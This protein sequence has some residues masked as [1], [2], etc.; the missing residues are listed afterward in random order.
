MRIEDWFLTPAERGNAATEIDRRR[1]DGTAWTRGQPTSRCSSTARVLPPALRG[2]LLSCSAATGCT[3]PTGR[4]IPTSA[5]TARAPRWHGCSRTCAARR[6]ARPRA[7][8]AVAP[9]PGALQRAGEPAPR[10]DGQ[11]RGRRGA[12]RRAGPTRREPP[13][14]AVRRPPRR[15][16][17]TTTSRS[18]AAS[19]SATAATTTT[20]TSATRRPSSS[21]RATDPGPPWHDVQLEVHGPGGRRPRVTRSAS[22]GTTRRRSTTATRCGAC[23][24]QVARAARADPTRC[25]RCRRDPAPCG[26]HAV[27][28]LRT[29]P[30]QAA[31][32]SRSR[33]TASAASPA[34]T[35]RRSGAP[36]RL[37][38][39]EDQYLWSRA[40][41]RRAGRRAPRATPSCTSSRSCPRY[42]DRDGRVSRTA[43]PH[44]AAAR[45]RAHLARAGGDRVAVYDLENDDGHAR[46]T[47]TPRSASSTTCG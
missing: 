25:R 30:G 12:A 43:V 40:R 4:A 7:A 34:P 24:A 6:R 5:S 31:A 15:R 14:E 35:S 10:R 38:Y 37:V 1:G 20:A 13:P 33:P 9:R 16:A 26:R 45:A 42:P 11:R 28:V 2:A 23:V 41:R 3:S 39:L 8:V 22:G 21:T 19:T 27:Q 17:P 47:C 46:S 32:L 36:R 29:Y 44:R 18:S